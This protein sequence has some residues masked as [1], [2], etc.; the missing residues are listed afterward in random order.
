M[1]CRQHAG[2]VVSQWLRRAS[3]RSVPFMARLGKLVQSG[4]HS[5]ER[6]IARLREEYGATRAAVEAVLDELFR[7]GVLDDGPA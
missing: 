5:A 3:P 2:W 4:Q 6:A 1:R 7:L